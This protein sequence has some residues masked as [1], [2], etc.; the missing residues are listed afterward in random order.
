MASH[1]DRVDARFLADWLYRNLRER[2]PLG[3]LDFAVSVVSDRWF[4]LRHGTSTGG[5]IAP[6]DLGADS[7]NV[8][9]SVRYQATRLRP[10]VTLM[11]HLSFPAGSVLVDVGCGKGKVVLIASRL[12]FARVVGVE[13]SPALCAIARRNV[14]IVRR[15]WPRMAPVEIVESDILDYAIHPEENVFYLYNPFDHVVM[16]RF[17]A[18]LEAS[19]RCTPRKIWLI[20]HVAQERD[21]VERRHLFGTS[22][23]H[24]V[25]GTEFIVYET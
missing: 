5:W 23:M 3:I 22:K 25:G 19:I 20:Y 12:G 1:S 8:R 21:V 11:K 6:E 17:I 18:R 14:E 13:F 9:H 4:D 15:R 2:G 7:E 10:F 16:E 24:R